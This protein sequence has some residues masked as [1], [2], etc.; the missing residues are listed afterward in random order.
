MQWRRRNKPRY[1]PPICLRTSNDSKEVKVDH[2]AT[3]EEAPK[4]Q[5]EGEGEGKEA[6]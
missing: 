3:E 2:Q 1:V 4:E 6:S 5:G